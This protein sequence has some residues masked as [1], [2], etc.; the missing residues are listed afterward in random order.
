MNISSVS[1][2]FLNGVAFP[3]AHGPRVFSV[4]DTLSEADKKLV[5]DATGWDITNDPRGERA[6]EDA[7][8]FAGRL[9]LD[10]AAGVLTGEIDSSY[11]GQLI[12]EQ[13]AGYRG[14]MELPV[15]LLRRAQGILRD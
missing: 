4:A 10:R 3:K 8:K 15:D 7:K 9:N 11:I 2:A 14:G 5:L 13:M 1:S 6:S 12:E